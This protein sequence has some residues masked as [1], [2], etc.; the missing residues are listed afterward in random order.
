M[1][2]PAA[3]RN[4]RWKTTRSPCTAVRSASYSYDAQ[5]QLTGV[6]YKTGSTVDRM[7]SYFYDAAGNRTNMVEILGSAT[8]TTGC[9][10]NNLN[11]PDPVLFS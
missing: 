6:T 2:L 9:A 3:E 1:T 10:A 4:G 5:D 11:H 7:V 8:N